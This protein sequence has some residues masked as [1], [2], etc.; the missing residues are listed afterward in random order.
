[1]NDVGKKFEYTLIEELKKT[2]IEVKKLGASGYPDFEL[3]QGNRVSYLEV[4]ATDNPKST[5]STFKTFYY[6]SGRFSPT[7]GISSSRFRRKRDR[8]SI[9][10][11]FRGRY[12]SA[13]IAGE[14]WTW[15]R[16]IA[17]TAERLCRQQLR[18]ITQPQAQMTATPS[19]KQ[20]HTARNILII[21][22]IIV[23]G[24]PA[25]FGFLAGISGVSSTHTESD[26]YPNFRPR[27]LQ[28]A[29]F[30]HYVYNHPQYP[31]RIQ[32][33]IYEAT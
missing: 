10:R 4:K 22:A 8:T 23:I 9:G 19:T 21:I 32:I 31:D 5:E 26:L 29:S 17:L 11:S 7:Q 33:S 14:S 16:S 28:R 3:K 1:M 24:I 13:L 25:V 18:T 2:P 30:S 20:P 6:S 15:I 27:Y 12:V